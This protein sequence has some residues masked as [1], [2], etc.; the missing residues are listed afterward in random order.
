MRRV[1]FRA[2]GSKDIGLG[3]I[4]RSLALVEMLG[5]DFRCVFITRDAGAQVKDMISQYCELWE[6]PVYNSPEEEAVALKSMVDR[7]DILVLDFYEFCEEYQLKLKPV[8]CNLVAIDDKAA[9]HFYTDLIINH[10]SG[11]REEL[12]RKEKYSRLLSGFPY[13]LIRKPFRDAAKQKRTIKAVKTLFV[14]LGGADPFNITIKAVQAASQCNF[15]EKIIIVTGTAYTNHTA[16]KA[17]LDNCPLQITHADNVG[18]A[19]MVRLI[20][21]CE[22]AICPSSSISLEVCSVRAGLLTGTVIDNQYG[23]HHQLIQAGCAVS[24][25]DFNVISVDG[26][27]D[28]INGLNDVSRVNEIISNQERMIDGLSGERILHEFKSLPAC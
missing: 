4:V 22:I 9:V 13:L 15:L 26:L 20:S 8:V 28:I 23:L 18:A 1:L 27:T 12:Y 16:L 25:G 21:S 11:G 3:H 24:A 19:E 10:G 17:V 7:N 5:N 2:D 6:L 14:C